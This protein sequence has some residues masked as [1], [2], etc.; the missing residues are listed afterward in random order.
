MRKLTRWTLIGWLDRG[1]GI[2]I[3]IVKGTLIVSLVVFLI[4]LIPVPEDVET[5][6][7]NSLLFRPVRSVA[8]AVF[9]FIKNAVP[10][11][12]DFYAEVREGFENTTETVKDHL[13]SKHLEK[14]QEDLEKTIK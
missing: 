9:N 4:S 11:T 10:Q 1:G 12:K 7:D 13:L 5:A 2:L 6:E 14:L 8:P 3:G